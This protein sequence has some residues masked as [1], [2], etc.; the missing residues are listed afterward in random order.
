M[1]MIDD[2]EITVSIVEIDIERVKAMVGKRLIR[3]SVQNDYLVSLE[4]EGGPDLVAGTALEGANPN[5]Q[6]VPVE[7]A[8]FRRRPAMDGIELPE[9]ERTAREEEAR[10]IRLERAN[11]DWLRR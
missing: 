6:Q 9:A 3:A 4:F 10:L 8:E 1:L 5:K 11:D 2:L 7:P